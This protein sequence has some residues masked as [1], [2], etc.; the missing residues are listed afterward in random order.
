MNAEMVLENRTQL[1]KAAG[2]RHQESTYNPKITTQLYWNVLAPGSVKTF[3]KSN[4]FHV[5]E[6]FMDSSFCFRRDEGIC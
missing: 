3:T 2:G 4:V 6:L 5:S 1:K